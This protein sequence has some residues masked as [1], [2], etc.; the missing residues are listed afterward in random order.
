LSSKPQKRF[1]WGATVVSRASPKRLSNI[2]RAWRARIIKAEAMRSNLFF[3]QESMPVEWR[4][5][6][7]TPGRTVIFRLYF[8]VA[9]FLGTKREKAVSKGA[10]V[11]EVTAFKKLPAAGGHA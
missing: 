10:T 9:D 1:S 8:D 11:R 2:K 7:G 4:R 3:S 6:N 5:Q